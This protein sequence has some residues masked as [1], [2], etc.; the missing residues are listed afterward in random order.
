MKDIKLEANDAVGSG[1][2]TVNTSMQRIHLD[3]KN[4][5]GSECSFSILR[6]EVIRLAVILLGGKI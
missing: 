5:F 4:E 3:F 2:L 1:V 6:S